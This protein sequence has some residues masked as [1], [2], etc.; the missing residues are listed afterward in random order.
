MAIATGAPGPDVLDVDVKPD[1][2]GLARIQ[3][4]QA[5][6]GC[7][8][9]AQALVRTPCGGLHSYYAGT[10]QRNGKL[11]RHHLDFR[12]D[13]GYVLAPP[14]RVHGSPTSCSTTAAGAAGPARLAG[15]QRT[16]RAARACQ[17][18]QPAALADL[19]GLAAWVAAQQEGNRN[20]GLFWAACR[21]ARGRP[22]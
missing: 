7:S 12:G 11:P 19:G 6:P 3:P 9:G 15:R 4:A 2:T 8:P 14:S 18:A 20:D 5:R 17:A 16:A 13:G 10:G 21:A 22:R 1:G